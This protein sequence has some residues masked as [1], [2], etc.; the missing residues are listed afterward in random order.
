MNLSFI[1]IFTASILT[2]FFTAGV[3]SFVISIAASVFYNKYYT[4]ELIKNGFRP[5]DERTEIELK[6]EGIFYN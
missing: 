2:G 6:N 3:G 1:A 4:E 5:F